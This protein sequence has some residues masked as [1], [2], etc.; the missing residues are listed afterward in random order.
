MKIYF[1]T[2]EEAQAAADAAFAYLVASSPEFAAS[3]AEGQT[4]CWDTPVEDENGWGIHI[5]ER[6]APAFRIT[7]SLL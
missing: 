3:V 6:V 2:Q 7:A 5:E 1:P 4:T